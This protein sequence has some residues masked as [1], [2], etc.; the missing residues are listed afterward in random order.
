MEDSAIL[1]ILYQIQRNLKTDY[2]K[3]IFSEAIEQIINAPS[4]QE[5]NQED[6]TKR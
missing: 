5:E 2:A 6:E 3:N 4:A 1:A